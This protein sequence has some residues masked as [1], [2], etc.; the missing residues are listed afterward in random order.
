MENENMNCK[1]CNILFKP[2]R[3]NQKFCC[4][5]CG[6]RSRIDKRRIYAKER[7]RLNKESER[8]KSK[9]YRLKNPEKVKESNRISN[10][11]RRDKRNLYLRDRS[12][13]DNLFRLK[14]SIRNNIRDS[15][16]RSSHRKNSNTE[17]ILGCSFQEF[18]NYLESKFKPWMSWDNY[19]KYNGME[20]F[21]W[22]LDH[23]IPSSYA[24]D[25]Q[26]LIQLNHYTNFQPLCS[27]INRDIK[28]DIYNG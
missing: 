27:Y 7:Y 23:I 25:E 1:F 2:Y 15:F 26:H 9:N 21:G 18:K 22:D 13:I 24:K 3:S 17:S 12:K 4:V 20:G 19:G 5:R 16:N 14:N 28:N 8:L 11:K 6:E 10:I